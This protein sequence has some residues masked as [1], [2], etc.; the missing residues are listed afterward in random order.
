M[1]DY[2]AEL[3]Y[4]CPRGFTLDCGTSKFLKEY[5][6]ITTN[7][8]WRKV[9]TGILLLLFGLSVAISK[10]QSIPVELQTPGVVSVN[11]M[12]MRASAFAFENR[13][14]AQTGEKEK[15]ARFISLNGSWKFNWVE[16]L[17][18]GRWI[19]I[20]QTLTIVNGLILRF[21]PIGN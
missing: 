1:T 20:D 13:E 12:P 17:R 4:S 10:A 11:R 6:M 21:P 14:L 5:Q 16:V 2:F 8:R 18:S 3:C 19:F 7:I 9:F 15:S